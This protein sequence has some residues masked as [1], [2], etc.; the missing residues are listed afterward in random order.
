M[1]WEGGIILVGVGWSGVFWVDW[2]LL[3]DDSVSGRWFIGREKE[4]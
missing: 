2:A 4:V 1:F 3:E